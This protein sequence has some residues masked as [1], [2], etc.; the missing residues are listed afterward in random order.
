MSDTLE[1]QERE[2]LTCE[3]S[4]KLSDDE[5]RNYLIQIVNALVK[6]N[7]VNTYPLR[8]MLHTLQYHHR[9]HYTCM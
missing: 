4:S 7:E 5:K 1:Q 6:G 3:I 8:N 2:Q 9:S